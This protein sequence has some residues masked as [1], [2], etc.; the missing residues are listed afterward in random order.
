MPTSELTPGS[1]VAGRYRLDRVIGS[2]G[3]GQVFRAMHLD[4]SR[5]VALKVLLNRLAQETR[6]RARFVR[7]AK[8][9]AALDHPGVVR[10]Y[11]FGD[12]DGLLFL[13]MELLTGEPLHQRLFERPPSVDEAVM[14]AAHVAGTLEHLHDVGVV[15][16]DIKPANLMLDRG[17][18]MDSARLVDFGTAFIPDTGA[19][20]RL[21]ADGLICG[22]PSYL[23]PEQARG[24]TITAATDVYSL[25]CVLFQMLTGEPPFR[26]LVGELLSAHIYQAPP[27]LGR[28]LPPGVTLPRAVHHVIAGMLEKKP[29]DRPSAGEVA[30]VLRA[31]P[32]APRGERPLHRSLGASASKPA[33]TAFGPRALQ[34]PDSPRAP[35]GQVLRLLAPPDGALSGA[36]AQRGVSYLVSADLRPSTARTV[37]YVGDASLDEIQ[38]LTSG[39]HQVVATCAPDDFDRLTGLAR[40]GAC[41]VLDAPANGSQV[42]ARLEPLLREGDA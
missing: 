35:A 9:L 36:L 27:A 11:D 3:S 22:T 29:E 19:L 28:L 6:V 42:A 4:L 17:G 12:D 2:G 33:P 31:D 23:S 30:V 21:T 1:I 7:E 16:R 15:H 38:T 39:G 40:V 24:T 8:V 20:G 37:W 25:G 41:D 14:L 34:T 5:P 26:G 32:D 10:V 18:A 13:S